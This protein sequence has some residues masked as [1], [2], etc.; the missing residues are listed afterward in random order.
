[1]RRALVLLGLC[2]CDALFGLDSL[3]YTADAQIDA[4][5]DAPRVTV[6]GLVRQRWLHNDPLNQPVLADN[7]LVT[8]AVSVHL[9]DGSAPDFILD[10]VTGVLTFEAGLGERYA[11]TLESSIGSYEYQLT[12]PTFTIEDATPGRPNQQ[13]PGPN[14][15]VTWTPPQTGLVAG[16]LR[17]I[18][19]GIWTTTVPVSV[20]ANTFTMSWPA[21]ANVSGQR[22]ALLSGADHDALYFVHLTTVPAGAMS[23]AYNI[24]DQSAQVLDATLNANAQ[25]PY[26]TSL[27]TLPRAHCVDLHWRRDAEYARLAQYSAFATRGG[28]VQLFAM[29]KASLGFR[30]PFEL[31]SLTSTSDSSVS[32]NY[33]NFF[34]GHDTLI[35]ENNYLQRTITGGGV[36]SV[37]TQYYD[38][39]TPATTC[40]RHDTPP[41][42]PSL[43]T[44]PTLG[45]IPLADDVVI[46]IDRTKPLE[47]RWSWDGDPAPVTQVNLVKGAG[48]FVRAYYATDDKMVIDPALLDESSSYR[49]AIVPVTGLYPNAA[50]GDFVVHQYPTS[51]SIL[52]TGFFR[53]VKN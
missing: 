3:D 26:S 30:V 20:V 45:G 34:P 16:N 19:T 2:G 28:T 38:V 6:N 18:S 27:Q 31:A 11:I 13:T 21:A 14:A 1:M 49:I 47:L 35:L 46:G 7:G 51:L 9:S 39:I 43:A 37:A 33:T 52:Q 53:V 48:T 23:P 40:T 50:S 10:P 25:T 4:A 22:P 15:A 44:T 42:A 36:I 17:F 29:A 5:P 24:I 8:D 32:I 41:T 12:S